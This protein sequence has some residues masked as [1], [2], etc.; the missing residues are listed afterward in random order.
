MRNLRLGLLVC[1]HVLEPLR[2]VAGD[3]PDMFRRLFV[4]HPAVELVGYDLTADV[5][6]DNLDECDGWITTGSRWSVYDDEPWIHRFADLVRAIQQGRHPFVGVCFGFQ[7]MAHALGGVV[8][9]SENGWGVGVKEV[10]LDHRASWMRD[11]PGS[12]RVLNS[13]ADQ[14]V[15]PPNG[16]VVLG[17]NDHCPVSIMQV[18]TMLGIQG[19]PEFVPE[20]SRAL[21]EIRRSLV[22]PEEVVDAGLSTLDQPIDTSR[23]ADW[24]VRFITDQLPD[25]RRTPE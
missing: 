3:Y 16:A 14:V 1:D 4:D 20:Y 15:Q 25:S 21:L 6:P 19:H 7:M 22:I 8:E 17:S 18:G 5:I 11:G 23:L 13:H 9:R 2:E 24:I 12:Y 10:Q